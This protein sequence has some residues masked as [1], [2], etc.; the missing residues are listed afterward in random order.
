MRVALVNMPVSQLEIPSLGLSLLKAEMAE[1][2]IHTDI[3][4]LSNWFGEAIGYPLYSTLARGEPMVHDLNAEWLFAEALWGPDEER[5]NDYLNLIVQGGSQHHQKKSSAQELAQYAER[6]LAARRK[7]GPFIER[8]LHQ[9][10]WSS[11]QVVGFSST[12]QQQIASLA[13]AKQLKVHFLD[14]FIIFGGANCEGPMGLTILRAFS[15]VDAVCLGEGDI[16][17]PTLIEAICSK[18]NVSV[19]VPGILQRAQLEIDI[20]NH[21][22]QNNNQY[23][24]I[25]YGKVTDVNKLPYPNFDDFFNQLTQ[26]NLEIRNHIYLIFES[27]RGCWWGEKSHCTFCGLNGS[28]MK[29]RQKSASRALA[30]L[31]WL[32]GRYGHY[33]RKILASDNIMPHEFLR[34]FLPA[35]CEL[36][37]DIELFYESK[38]NLRKEDIR[39]YRDVGM[40][41]FQPGIESLSTPVLRLMRKG[42]SSGL[43]NVQILKWCRQFG[44]EPSWNYLVGFPGEQPEHYEEQEAWAWAIQHLTPPAYCGPI[45]FDRFS[46]YFVA[47]NTFEVSKL[48]PYPSYRFIYPELN[49][50]ELFD[51]AYF[52]IGEFEGQ[53]KINE[54]TLPLR[55]AIADWQS[56]A[57]RYSLFSI[58]TKDILLICDSRKGAD[59][60]ILEV[61]GPAMLILNTCS[62]RITNRY[63]LLNLVDSRKDVFRNI[64]VLEQALTWL[65]HKRLL[66]WEGENCISLVIPLGDGYKPP[67]VGAHHL[68][69]LNLADTEEIIVTSSLGN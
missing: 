39:L 2:N 4:Y 41:N 45:R 66:L 33:T 36:K 52:F 46:P 43:H 40:R 51:I 12:F 15:F 9:I 22:S 54:Y 44:L 16:S 14:L 38:A 32:L 60:P 26:I 59:E 62:D 1:R 7:V 18:G 31:R 23:H 47:P 56:N 21:P 8:C 13:L 35:L 50:D 64:Q 6:L 63:S 42:I 61:S 65:T 10:N 34:E 58:S 55:N 48:Q 25:N 67:H 5:D 11:Y 19:V 69:S 57:E 3:H 68:S 17:F 27:S 49:E 53:D 24:N 28:S 37:I 20:P 29:F 30:E